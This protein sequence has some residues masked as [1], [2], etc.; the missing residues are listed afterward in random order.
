MARGFRRSGFGHSWALLSL[1]LYYPLRRT[2]YCCYRS[3]SADGATSAAHEAG[4]Q[5]PRPNVDAVD[6][7]TV[8]LTSQPAKAKQTRICALARS[9][10]ATPRRWCSP[11]SH[12]F[13][14]SSITPDNSMHVDSGLWLRMEC[15]M[16]PSGSPYAPTNRLTA[17]GRGCQWSLR[18][19]RAARKKKSLLTSVQSL[20]P[21]PMLSAHHCVLR[22][23]TT[24]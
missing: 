3:S 13:P 17:C 10:E 19:G 7:S 5:C 24:W 8:S 6:F 12:A 4:R 21:V 2:K 23:L 18:T 15:S 20:C 9:V 16:T 14:G 1:L 11:P 22:T